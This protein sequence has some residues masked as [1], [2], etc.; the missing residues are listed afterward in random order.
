MHDNYDNI[1]LIHVD[2]PHSYA[3]VYLTC[4]SYKSA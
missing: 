2:M 1:Q 3:K 4:V